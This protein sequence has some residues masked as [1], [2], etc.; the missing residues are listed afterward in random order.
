MI[1]YL[2]SSMVII[3]VFGIGKREGVVRA[4]GAVAA[5]GDFNVVAEMVEPRCCVK[6]ICKKFN[7]FE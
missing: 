7:T 5:D 6:L 4:N 1:E 3:A 2:L